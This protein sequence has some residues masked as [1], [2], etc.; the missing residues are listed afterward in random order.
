MKN[1]R[2]TVTLVL[3]FFISSSLLWSKAESKMQVPNQKEA[4]AYFS[5]G[6]FWCVEAV[7]ESVKGVSEAISGY[8]GGTTLNPTYEQVGYG[9]SD[10]AETVEVHYNPELISFAELVK[11]FFGS[12]DPT[13]L[14]RQGPDTGT[15]YRSIAFYSNEA[16]K[17]IIEDHIAQLTADGVYDRPIVTEVK[18]I[19]IFYKAEDYHQNYESNNPFS[20]YIINVSKPRFNR[21][22]QNYS[23]YLKDDHDE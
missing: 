3:V 7:Y 5:G 18:S 16:E 14:N 19:G 6:C 10:H 23:E 17:K 20:P 8:A 2:L 11:L 22:K 1:N 12:H 13:T 9:Q 4:V 21:F 15:Q